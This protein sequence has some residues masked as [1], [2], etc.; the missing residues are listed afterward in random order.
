MEKLHVSF[1]S[2]IKDSL[3]RVSGPTEG[4][5]VCF[6]PTASDS[7]P[8]EDVWQSADQPRE[9]LIQADVAREKWR[10]GIWD[11]GDSFLAYPDCWEANNANDAARVVHPIVL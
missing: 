6:P 7:T 8:T 10:V 2:S 9:S 4:V 3:S 5:G 1:P 11:F